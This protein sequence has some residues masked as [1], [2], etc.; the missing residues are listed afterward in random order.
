MEALHVWAAKDVQTSDIEI[1]QH[2]L[3]ARMG[4]STS[5]IQRSQRTSKADLITHEIQQIVFST[6]HSREVYLLF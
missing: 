2:A 5:H 6:R 3:L 4:K 1:R